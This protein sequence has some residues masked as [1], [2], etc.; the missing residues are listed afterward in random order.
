MAEP[1]ADAVADGLRG[2]VDVL[3]AVDVLERLV[4]QDGL[5]RRPT[6]PGRGAAAAKNGRGMPASVAADLVGV[7][8]PAAEF[9]DV[10][11][12]A[13]ELSCH[14]V[15]ATAS[16]RRRR[17][18][19]SAPPLSPWA[20]ARQSSAT[21]ARFAGSAGSVPSGRTSGEAGLDV[22]RERLDPG[23]LPGLLEGLL[24]LG[25]R[26]PLFERLAAATQASA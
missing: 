11:G 2:V 1:V 14:H 9:R 13:I 7:V 15:A 20:N 17:A 16:Y 22:A 24:G 21:C 23:V 19:R 26:L 6:A 3:A 5:A 12:H 10:D 8:P 25:D 18:V 4:Q